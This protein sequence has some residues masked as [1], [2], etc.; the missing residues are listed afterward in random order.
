M[1]NFGTNIKKILEPLLAFNHNKN[2]EK[3]LKSIHK[4]I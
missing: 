2:K 4:I 3:S 1:N